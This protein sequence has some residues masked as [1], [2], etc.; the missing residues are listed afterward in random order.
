MK[1]SSILFTLGLV[2]ILSSCNAQQKDN[3]SSRIA[4]LLFDPKIIELIRENTPNEITRLETEITAVYDST[5]S[6]TLQPQGIKFCVERKQFE[7]MVFKLKDQFNSMGYKIFQME[8]NYDAQC[9]QI[10]VLKTNDQFDI[11]RSLGTNGINYGIETDSLITVLKKWNS[12]N[13]FE[14]IAAGHDYV[15]ARYIGKPKDFK[16]LSQ[17]MFNF[18]PDIVYQGAETVERLEEGIEAM[19]GLYLWWD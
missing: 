11:L 16:K 7:S 13:E 3:S 1:R 5:N 15:E 10:G 2:I 6:R 9:L 14:I 17:E 19:N 8:Y 18:C 12:E 4:D